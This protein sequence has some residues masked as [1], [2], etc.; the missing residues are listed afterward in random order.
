MKIF[1]RKNIC[2]A[3]ILAMLLTMVGCAS[4][5][6]PAPSTPAAPVETAPPTEAVSEVEVT[7]PPT[8]PVP[9]YNLQDGPSVEDILSSSSTSTKT[10]SWKA[11]TDVLREKGFLELSDW[12][13]SSN[14]VWDVSVIYTDTAFKMEFSFRNFSG[15]GP[16]KAVIYGTTHTEP[17]NISSVQLSDYDKVFEDAAWT[18]SEKVAHLDVCPQYFEYKLANQDSENSSPASEWGLGTMWAWGDLRD[19]A[20]VS[21]LVH[22]LGVYSPGNQNLYNIVFEYNQPDNYDFSSP[23]FMLFNT[24]ATIVENVWLHSDLKAFGLVY[25]DSYYMEK[26]MSTYMFFPAGMNFA[27]WCESEYNI[28]KWEFVD[29]GGYGEVRVQ[30]KYSVLVNYKLEADGTV[31][32]DTMDVFLSPGG[33]TMISVLPAM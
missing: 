25:P 17:A 18:D 10:G 7:E 22:L 3:M 28:D 16:S 5:S 13:L 32:M 14:E 19:N 2:V 4:N 29:H 23:L 30:D 11:C 21:Q 31:T 8:E 33:L 1:T 9:Q 6:T 26:N 15:K 27:E 24:P 20:P 12:E